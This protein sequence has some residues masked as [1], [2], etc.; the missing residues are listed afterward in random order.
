MQI[1]P[2]CIPGNDNLNARHPW[3]ALGGLEVLNLGTYLEKKGD[4][5][6]LFGNVKY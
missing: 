5:F 4:V 1:I 3:V 6:A 2:R